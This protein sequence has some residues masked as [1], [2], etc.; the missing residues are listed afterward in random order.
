MP[1]RSANLLS[2]DTARRLAA[3]LAAPSSHARSRPSSPDPKIPLLPLTVRWSA[4]LAAPVAYIPPQSV[5]GYTLDTA[6]LAPATGLPQGWYAVPIPSS[7]KTDLTVILAL[8]PKDTGTLTATLCADPTL[9][10]QD[11]KPTLAAILA[12]LDTAA[13][14]AVTLRQITLGAIT[15]LPPSDTWAPT[16]PTI[17]YDN[18]LG[19]VHLSLYWAKITPPQ[20][21][22]DPPTADLRTDLGPASSMRLIPLASLFTNQDSYSGS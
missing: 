3:A 11:P 5:A 6:S 17:N 15:G 20:K 9:I 2:G 14:P 12:T 18:A 10:P 19:T 8:T 22:G 7:G 21:D 13:A 1:I 16:A 4:A